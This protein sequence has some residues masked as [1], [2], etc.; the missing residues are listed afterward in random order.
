M[1]FSGLKVPVLKRAVADIRK[2]EE[3]LQLPKSG[4]Q[5]RAPEPCFQD[6]IPQKYLKTRDLSQYSEK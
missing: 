1:I 4:E 6:E 5:V 3:A 2:H